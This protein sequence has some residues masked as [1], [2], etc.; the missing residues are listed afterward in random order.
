MSTFTVNHVTIIK[1]MPKRKRCLR[2]VP[3]PNVWLFISF[4]STM[5]CT[6]MRHACFHSPLE[7]LI[8]VEASQPESN[9][10]RRSSETEVHVIFKHMLNRRLQKKSVNSTMRTYSIFSLTKKDQ[11]VVHTGGVKCVCQEE[12]VAAYQSRIFHL[13]F[14]PVITRIQTV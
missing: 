13:F 9:S 12:P 8:R 10:R 14:F 7:L 5:P 3:P 2:K 1:Y 11:T 6:E 4:S